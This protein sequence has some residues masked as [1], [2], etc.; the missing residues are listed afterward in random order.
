[1][2]RAVK[3]TAIGLVCPA[4]RALVNLWVAH[5]DDKRK[6]AEEKGFCLQKS[7]AVPFLDHVL[8][9]L[10]KDVVAHAFDVPG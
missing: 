1:M 2:M 10:L 7:S 3:R 8:F 4:D 9:N 6:C 5:A